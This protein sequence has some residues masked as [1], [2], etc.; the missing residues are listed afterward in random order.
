MSLQFQKQW[1]KLENNI[2]MIELIQIAR[3]IN[4]DDKSKVEIHGFCDA[5]EKT[6]AAAVYIRVI[7]NNGFAI[8]LLGAKT[9]VT[10]LNKNI[11]IF[12]D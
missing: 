9:R 2:K 10:P 8:T 12:N 3:F 5:L 6:Y 4:S 11:T 7:N 1:E